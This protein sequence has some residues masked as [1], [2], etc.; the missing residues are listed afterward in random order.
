VIRTAITEA[1]FD[2]IAKTMPL[3]SVGYEDGT[4]EKDERLIWLAPHG[5]PAAGNARS[6]RELQRCDPQ[7]GGWGPRAEAVM[8]MR[9]LIIATA[10]VSVGVSPALAETLFCSTS[11]QGYR[12]C[13]DGHGYRSTEWEWQ[14]MTIGQ[15]SDGS[16]WTTSRWRDGDIT[17]VTRPER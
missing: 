10:F 16:R 5:E 14:G 15:D 12:V 9:A 6:E 4:N 2:A 3:G 1:A 17:T 11:F 8:T 7:A 13:D